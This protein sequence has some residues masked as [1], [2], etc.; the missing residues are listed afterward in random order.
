[1]VSGKCEGAKLFVLTDGY[2]RNKIQF[3]FTKIH[4]AK[5][6]GIEMGTESDVGT[7]L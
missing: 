2:L 4:I 5:V 1:M 3:P 6:Q 7:D